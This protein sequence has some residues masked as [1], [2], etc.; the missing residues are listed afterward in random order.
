M[1]NAVVTISTDKKSKCGYQMKNRPLC[2]ILGR[3]GDS[4]KVHKCKQY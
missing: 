4:I 3:L 2:I 1:T